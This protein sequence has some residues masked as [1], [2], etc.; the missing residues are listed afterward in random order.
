MTHVVHALCAEVRRLD[1]E[2]E[3]LQIAT[4]VAATALR[5]LGYA[6]VRN[7]SDGTITV[8]PLS[9]IEA[10]TRSTN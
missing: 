4:N 9:Q 10:A 1:E 3:Q 5:H 6:F 8:A 7:P 2:N